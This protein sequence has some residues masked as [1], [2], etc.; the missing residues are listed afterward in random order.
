MDDDRFEEPLDK[1]DRDRLQIL[2]D[3]NDVK[4]L[5]EI[6]SEEDEECLQWS[7]CF[8]D[9]YDMGCRVDSHVQNRGLGY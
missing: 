2:V 7:C 4:T 5:R 9:I 6:L 1:E 3:D 8:A